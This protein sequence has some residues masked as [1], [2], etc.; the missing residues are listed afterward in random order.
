MSINHGLILL[1]LIFSFSNCIYLSEGEFKDI[2]FMKPT[3]FVID[4]ENKAYFQYKLDVKKGSIGLKFLKANSYTVNVTT[5]SS[6]ENKE[7]NKTQ[8]P[9]AYNQFKEINVS[10][11]D[12][13]YVYIVIEIT[14]ENY[15]YDDYLTIYDSERPIILEHNK[16]ISINNFLS[17]QKYKFLF[18][19]EKKNQL[20]SFITQKIMMI[21]ID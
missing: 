11:F 10:T 20:I 3:K 2:E 12:Q 8:Y 5:F 9:L 18:Q 6:L 4:Y 13:G 17:V 14:K 16:V 21:I 1:T 15:T 19:T 7:E